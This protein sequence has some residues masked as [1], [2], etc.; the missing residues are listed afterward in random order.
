MTIRSNVV[1]TSGRRRVIAE[2]I[3]LERLNALRKVPA[4]KP[5]HPSFYKFAF[6]SRKSG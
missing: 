4:P 2:A 5:T 3:L 1:S 6:Y